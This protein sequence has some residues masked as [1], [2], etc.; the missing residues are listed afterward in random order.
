M[1]KKRIERIIENK[2]SLLLF[3]LVSSMF[4]SNLTVQHHMVHT[5]AGSFLSLV[6]FAIMLRILK[7]HWFLLF[8]YIILSSTAL[9]FHY[10]AVL[11]FRSIALGVVA[12]I[13]YIVM[14]GIT[15]IFMIRRIFSERL[16]TSDTI[17][18]GISV[19]ILMANWWQLIYYFLYVLDQSSFYFASGVVHQADF[20]YY[21]VMTM[22]TVGFGDIVPRSYAARVF[23]MFQAVAG[24]LYVAIFVARLV[25]LHIAGHP[26]RK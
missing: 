18:G 3:F 24:Q 22:T 5:I 14:I 16:V 2:Y 9:V 15:I 7:A 12:I 11:V 26:H 23:S 6:V 20:L 13:V 17:K 25:G 8:V 19:Y 10:L 1:D 21:S 4:V